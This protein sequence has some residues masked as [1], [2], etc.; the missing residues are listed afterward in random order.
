MQFQ[1]GA[2]CM[3]K[4]ICAAAILAFAVLCGGTVRAKAEEPSDDPLYGRSEGNVSPGFY[5][6]DE[7]AWANGISTFSDTVSPRISISGTGNLV[8]N[9]IFAGRNIRYG[10]DV[11]VYQKDIDWN[12]AR[13]NGVEFVFIRV[14]Y[15]GWGTGRMCNDTNFEKNIQGAIAAGIRVGVYFYSQAINTDEAVEEAKYVL[16]KIRGYDV[17]LPVVM[18]YEYSGS[19][20]SGDRLLNA[21]LS[22]DQMTENVLAFCGYCKQNGYTAMLYAN[23]NFLENSVNDEEI[24]ALY[25]I[26]LAH[27]TDQTGYSGNYSFWQFTSSGNVSGISGN[28]DLDVWYDDG[29]TVYNCENL[30]TDVM[31]YNSPYFNAIYWARNNGYVL[32]RTDTYFAINETCTRG[33]FVTFLWRMMGCPEPEKPAEECGITDLPSEDNPYYKA[34]LWAVENDIVKGYEDQTFRMSATC[35]RG[36]IMTLLYRLSGDERAEIAS[37]FSDVTDPENAYYEGILWGYEN[38]IAKGFND[39]TFG[40]T[41]GCTRGQAVTFLYRMAKSYMDVFQN[42]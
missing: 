8:H 25:P 26:W 30:F 40:I 14:G 42:S 38:E 18:D 21:H 34:I 5:G 33:Q 10:M 17:S 16:D 37:P 9:S 7:T 13:Q 41:T 1:K 6:E 24:S 39:G 4:K 20:S 12:A 2:V 31:N 11:S 32:G 23:K 36:A 22:K 15:R 29:S 27:Y 19:G 35:S 28:V 3:I